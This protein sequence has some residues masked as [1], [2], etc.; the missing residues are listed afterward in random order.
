MAN[1]R[2]F[3]KRIAS[4]AIIS[5]LLICAMALPSCQSGSAT[6]SQST[7]DQAATERIKSGYYDHRVASQMTRERFEE[8]VA[9][10]L[11]YAE[12]SYPEANILI[13]NNTVAEGLAT[14][15]AT[16][17]ASHG[18]TNTT[19]RNDENSPGMSD[20]TWIHYYDDQH[21]QAAA[22]IAAIL[23]LGNSAVSGPHDH[24]SE[25]SSEEYDIIVDLGYDDVN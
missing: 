19:V 10:G 25:H 16:V 8:L 5:I 23:G 2:P 1:T 24:R 6:D 21:E 13:A 14:N 20:V 7:V 11:D 12:S 17:L 3:E 18:F 4:S 15:A 9:D 22:Q